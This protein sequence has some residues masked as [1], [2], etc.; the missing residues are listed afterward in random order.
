MLGM[1]LHL[2]A[3]GHRVSLFGY[4]VRRHPLAEICERFVDH[5]RYVM[6]TEPQGAGADYA[7]VGHSLGGVIARAASARLPDGLS[8]LV[9]LGPPNSSPALAR[10]G[11][12]SPLYVAM[13]RDAGKLL[14]EHAFY[15][16]L[17]VPAAPTLVI[18]GDA[19]PRAPWLPH[20]GPAPNDGIVSVEETRLPGADHRVM[21]LNHTFMMMDPRALRA[22]ADFLA[23]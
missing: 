5:V 12:S 7:V 3:R 10:A 17:P 15:E 13:T 22:V 2:R 20:R 1:G 11:R 18:A 4:R 14:G 19:G 21:P 8:R 16:T 23:G 9:M 6:D